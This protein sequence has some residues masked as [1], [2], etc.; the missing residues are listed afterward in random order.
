VQ[1]TATSA[2]PGG[3]L[4]VSASV[5]RTEPQQKEAHPISSRARGAY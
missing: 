5:V 4:T 2:R 3:V 1:I